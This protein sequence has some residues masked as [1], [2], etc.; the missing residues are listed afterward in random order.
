MIVVFGARGRIYAIT[1]PEAL[2][3]SAV[4]AKVTAASRRTFSH[5]SVSEAEFAQRLSQSGRPASL[6][7]DLTKENA[8]RCHRLFH[9]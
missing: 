1:G 2:T 3:F 6:A 7:A 5:V 4:A 8:L 9:K